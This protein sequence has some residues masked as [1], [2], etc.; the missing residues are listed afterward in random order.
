MP[1][2]PRS[3]VSASYRLSPEETTAKATE[4]EKRAMCLA[5]ILLETSFRNLNFN[6]ERFCV[7]PFLGGVRAFML[8][9]SGGFAR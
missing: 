2:E 8:Y 1:Q 7:N 6:V 3:A 9:Q 4:M 5:M